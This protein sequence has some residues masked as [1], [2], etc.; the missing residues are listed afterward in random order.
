MPSPLNAIAHVFMPNLL[1][2]KGAQTILG[3]VERKE[4]FFFDVVW[5]QAHVQHDVFMHLNTE[6]DPIRVAVIDLPPPKEMGDAYFVAIVGHKTDASYK[7]YF[8]LEYDY[9]LSTKSDRTL[10][11]ERDGNRV[12]KHFEGPPITGDKAVDAEAFA[13]ALVPL[14]K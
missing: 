3:V 14:V 4:K 8:L 12:V 5:N 6:R 10:I 13:D 11:T 1:R 7:R 2:T 9:Q